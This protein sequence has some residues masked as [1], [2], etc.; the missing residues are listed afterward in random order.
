MKKGLIEFLEDNQVEIE[1]LVEIGAGRRG[2]A[3]LYVDEYNMIGL[4]KRK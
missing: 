3:Y 4:I 2:T 1:T